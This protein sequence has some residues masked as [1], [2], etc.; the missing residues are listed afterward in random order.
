MSREEFLREQIERE[1][2]SGSEGIELTEEQLSSI[3]GG[4]D[5]E[6]AKVCPNCGSKN[7]V[8]FYSPSKGTSYLCADCYHSFSKKNQ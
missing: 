5:D 3:T 1:Q 2:M 8:P 7:I 6:R 4:D